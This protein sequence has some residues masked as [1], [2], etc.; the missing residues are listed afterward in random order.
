[1]TT[2]TITPTDNAQFD[3]YKE[4]ALNRSQVERRTMNVWEHQG[5]EGRAAT[6]YMQVLPDEMPD[7]PE[8][9]VLVAMVNAAEDRNRI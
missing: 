3:R 9:W 8:G 7:P 1:M 6:H 4:I 2:R 5:R